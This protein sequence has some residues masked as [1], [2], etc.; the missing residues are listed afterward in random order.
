MDRIICY[1]VSL[2]VPKLIFWLL[3][4]TSDY[5]GAAA[6]TSR[7]KDISLRIGM[8]EGIG[9]LVAIGVISFQVTAHL[10]KKYYQEKLEKDIKMKRISS[11]DELIEHVMEK[12]GI[13]K[14]LKAQIVANFILPD[15]L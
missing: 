11:N 3:K 10:F 13:S 5:E 12:Y 2:A 9:V 15:K 1:I 6:M 8:E 4:V 7:L 14:H